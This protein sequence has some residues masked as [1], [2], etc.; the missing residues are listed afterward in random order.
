RRNSN[1]MRMKRGKCMAT[2]IDLT[3]KAKVLLEKKQIF[4][5]KAQIVL[6]LDISGSMR[7]LYKN[8]TV[9]ELVNRLLA[10]GMNMDDNKSIEVFVFGSGAGEVSEANEFN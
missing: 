3:K 2:L 9:Q 6:I 7:P 5:E 10:I 4:G 8:G 1:L